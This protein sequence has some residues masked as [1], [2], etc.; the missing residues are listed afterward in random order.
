MKDS[1]SHFDSVAWEVKHVTLRDGTKTDLEI[2]PST[3]HGRLGKQFWPTE[4]YYADQYRNEFSTSVGKFTEVEQREKVYSQL[5]LRQFSMIS[6]I[7]KN[8]KHYL[9]VGASHGGVAGYAAKANP[10]LALTLVE[11]NTLDADYLRSKFP[12]AD[13]RNA[14]FQNADLGKYKYDVFVAL[15]VLEHTPN[16]A[17]FLKRVWDV[18][19]SGASIV[20]E[21]P[22]HKEALLSF[23]Q[24]YN[25]FYYHK[26][27]LHYFTEESLTTLMSESGFVGKVRG[28]QMYSFFNFMNWA[29]NS[30]PQESALEALSLPE[31][32][33]EKIAK[34][35]EMLGLFNSFESQ[36]RN[37][38]QS[39]CHSDCLMYIGTKV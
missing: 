31:Q 38:V 11:P 24:N 21:V 25:S 17:D 26:A 13:V 30:H 35:P 37:S 18:L 28:F 10:N 5:N 39:S 15:E 2:D 19:E 14:M 23:D 4:S 7:L 1:K 22:N 36:F 6:E 20:I 9:E 33:L 3:K 34:N 8:K 16:P 27:H 29:I 32:F 12:N